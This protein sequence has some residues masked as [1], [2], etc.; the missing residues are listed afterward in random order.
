MPPSQLPLPLGEEADAADFERPRPEE[1]IY[2]NRSLR[3]DRI[4]VVGFDMDYTLAVYRQEAMDRRS[5]EATLPKLRALGYPPEL[6]AADVRLDFGV[7]GL[8]VDRELGNVLKMD[9]YRYVKRAYHGY[10]ELAVEERRAH[11]HKK[12]I[13]AGG[14]FHFVD[15]LYALCEVA[16]FASLVDAGERLGTKVD[17][18]QLFKDIRSSVDASH[19][20]GT[21]LD[22]VLAR[23][24]HYVERDPELATALHKLRSSGKRLFLLTNSQPAYTDALMSF[25]LEGGVAGYSNWRR[26]F[27]AVVTA[28]KKPSFFDGDTPFEE[29]TDGKRTQAESLERGHTY[30]GGNLADFERMLGVGG[31]QVLYVGDHIYG[32]VLRAKKEG[33][34]RTMMI[35]EE[36]RHELAQVAASAELAARME[37]IE[38]QRERVVDEQ[39]HL[40]HR[41]KKAQRRLDAAPDETARVE[42]E[43]ELRRVRREL[44]AA[45]RKLDALEVEYAALEESYDVPFH[46]FWGSIFRSGPEVSNFGDQIE[47]FACLYTTRAANLRHYSAAH[48]FQSPRERMPHEL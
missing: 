35:V 17:Y 26:Y 42:A 20:D 7:R 1:R 41:G 31:E 19:Q 2:V 32:D 30:V 8:L 4:E 10:R 40:Q 18:D 25:L 44:E 24:E 38:R 43:A 13:T 47:E 15:T 5:I 16:L 6:L 48:F 45:R 9:R 3:M 27:D 33:A 23:P 39:R 21:I 11:Y 29:W 36:L 34:W 28:A 37:A 14:R 22:D 12:R 46:P